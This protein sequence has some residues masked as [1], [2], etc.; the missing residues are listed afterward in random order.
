MS[1]VPGALVALSDILDD[2]EA[3]RIATE[4]RLRMLTRDVADKDGKFRGY[5]IADDAPLVS[6]VSKHLEALSA[7]EHS[8]ELDLKRAIRTS[9]F[10]TWVK[11]TPG[12]GEKQA[13]RLLG[14]LGDPY[15]NETTGE[16]RTVS[17]LW[18]YSG[19][20]RIKDG[21]AERIPKGAKQEDILRLGKP[22]I[23]S[24]TWLIVQSCI[25][26]NKGRYREMYDMERSYYADAIHTVD[27]ANCKVKAGE[28]L[29]PGHQH[30][31]AVRKVSKE[32]LRDLWVIAREY[33]EGA[34][35]AEGGM[36]ELVSS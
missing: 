17:Q 9:A 27:C 21:K 2:T 1:L 34:N 13:A 24:R 4:N 29:S 11:N 22:K 31:R 20:G 5:G 32:I 30:A 26:A 14:A 12:V 7:M 15:V 28:P 25:K 36:V 8:L 6:T 35:I 16:I 3:L 18:A 23:K 33:H 19:Y 10:A